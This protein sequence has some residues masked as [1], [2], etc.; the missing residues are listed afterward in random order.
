MCEYMQG[1]SLG[2]RL[3]KCYILAITCTLSRVLYITGA[4]A[5]ESS[6]RFLVMQY[7]TD[8]DFMPLSYYPPPGYLL[9]NTEKGQ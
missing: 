7:I 3:R 9:A 6:Y 1:E 4:P 5:T 8:L 2:K